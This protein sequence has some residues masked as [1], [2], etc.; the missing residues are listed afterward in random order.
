MRNLLRALPSGIQINS[1][2]FEHLINS[3][4]A[5]TSLGALAF[6]CFSSNL[7]LFSQ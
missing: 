5:N 6:T 7:I 3:K 1:F 2:N 4:V